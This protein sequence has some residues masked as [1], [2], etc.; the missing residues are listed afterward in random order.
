MLS[1]PPFWYQ[2]LFLQPQ[3]FQALE[4]HWRSLL[5]QLLGHT[6][7]FWGM[8]DLRIQES[9]LNEHT[10]ELAGGEFLFPDG[11]PVAVPGLAPAP[12]RSFRKDWADP[13]LP[14]KAYLG[15]RR[16]NPGAGNV[17]VLE[18]GDPGS[19]PTRFV[20][21]LEPEEVADTHQGGAPGQVR[22]L[23]PVLRLFW[24]A[25]LPGL[26]D[27]S[28]LPVAVLVQSRGEVRLDPGFAPPAFALGGCPALRNVARGI[29]DQ[30]AGQVRRLEAFKLAP[31][32]QNPE[33]H[34]T[35]GQ[36]LMALR[37]LAGALPDLQHALEPPVTHPWTVYGLLRRL[38]GELSTFTD[39]VN[40][41][42]RL[43]DGRSLLPEYDHDNPLPCFEAAQTLLA[44]LL[45]S[46]LAGPRKILDLVRDGKDFRAVLPLDTFDPL[47]AYFLAVRSAGPREAVLRDLTTLAKLGSRE[48]VPTLVARALSGV[49][50]R[51]MEAPPAGMPKHA[52][53]YYFRLDLAHP[54]WA[55]VQAS[56]TLCLH[57]DT[58]P[59]DAKA[60]LVVLRK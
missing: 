50:L 1:R 19:A 60:E 7:F 32:H 4:Q 9:R 27:Y 31:E 34:A 38:V 37:I 14:F 17:T 58:A 43:E 51:P 40:A 6:P 29:R 41:L 55:E 5:A 35:Y 13:T 26:G 42:G 33:F 24:E 47:H 28:L 20:T 45:G 30:V 52:G 8:R 46:V 44:E 10:L 49:P 25:E 22:L 54:Q 15:L 21:G 59:E 56:Q 53:A 12:V 57:W 36:Y 48:Q 23:T 39:R 3:H 11:T 18:A 16:W 2:G